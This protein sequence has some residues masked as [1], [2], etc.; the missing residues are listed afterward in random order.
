MSEVYHRLDPKGV[1]ASLLLLWNDSPLST[2]E[3]IT[4]C[5]SFDDESTQSSSVGAS[6]ESQ[7]PTRA[8]TA[9]CPVWKTSCTVEFPKV[10][11]VRPFRR[12]KNDVEHRWPPPRLCPAM[13][14]AARLA[15]S[16]QALHLGTRPTL[17]LASL[18]PSRAFQAP[19]RRQ[20]MHL[21]YWASP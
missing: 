10:P 14:K 17:K 7:D 12:S 9:P 5:G 16:R 6:A 15:C 11:P 18:F 19:P 1:L 4:R 8:R 20:G 21:I 13:T 3:R 2:K